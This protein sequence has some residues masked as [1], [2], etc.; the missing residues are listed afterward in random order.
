[1]REEVALAVDIYNG[2]STWWQRLLGLAPPVSMHLNLPE[3]AS[4]NVTWEEFA[5]TTCLV[6]FIS[7]FLQTCRPACS[8]VVWWISSGSS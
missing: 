2:T 4:H 6:Q 8:V 7:H 3:G 5:Y 1:M